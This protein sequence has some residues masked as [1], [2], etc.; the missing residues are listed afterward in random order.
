MEALVF[1]S[2]QPSEML[3]RME[4]HEQPLALLAHITNRQRIPT[5]QPCSNL[6]SVTLDLAV[7]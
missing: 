2:V 6:I 5:T 1:T 7:H 3:C 4:L